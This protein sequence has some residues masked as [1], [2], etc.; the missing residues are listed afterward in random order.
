MLWGRDVEGR[1]DVAAWLCPIL[2]SARF[3][4]T[5][6]WFASRQTRTPR[7]HRGSAEARGRGQEWLRLR[8]RLKE[9]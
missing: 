3:D 8:L 7:Y 1:E 4:A 2:L 5:T 9:P 6:L